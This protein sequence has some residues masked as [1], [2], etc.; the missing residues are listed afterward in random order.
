M[1][2]LRTIAALVGTSL[3]LAGAGCNGSSSG[4]GSWSSNPNDTIRQIKAEEAQLQGQLEAG[5]REA[6]GSWGQP[7]PGY[8]TPEQ[9]GFQPR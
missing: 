8:Q 5:R 1:R 3:G 7:D 6:Q 4:Q 2:K 9:M